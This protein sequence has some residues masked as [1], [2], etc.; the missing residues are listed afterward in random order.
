LLE[1]A[2]APRTT[3]QSPLRAEFDAAKATAQGLR[4]A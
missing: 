4:V 3:A 2:I 1:S